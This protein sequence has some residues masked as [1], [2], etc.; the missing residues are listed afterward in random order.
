MSTPTSSEAPWSVTG[1]SSS[2]GSPAA[3]T[4]S[5][6]RSRQSE[7]ISPERYTFQVPFSAIPG[8]LGGF[9]AKLSVYERNA[10]SA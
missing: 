9:D 6:I 5:A 4:P 7:W 10:S 2:T 1:A 3:R 8:I